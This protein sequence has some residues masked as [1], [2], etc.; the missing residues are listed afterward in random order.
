MRKRLPSNQQ[1]SEDQSNTQPFCPSSLETL[2]LAIL[3]EF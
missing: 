3:R 2:G 1:G